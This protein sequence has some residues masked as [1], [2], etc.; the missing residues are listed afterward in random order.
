[1]EQYFEHYAVG[2]AHGS[3]FIRVEEDGSRP[4]LP[5]RFLNL[6]TQVMD[7]HPAP[8]STDWLRARDLPNSNSRRCSPFG[9]ECRAIVLAVRSSPALNNVNNR[10][11][12]ARFKDGRIRWLSRAQIHR[13][14]ST[15]NWRSARDRVRAAP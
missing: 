5:V 11:D 12:V 10:V 14:R 6:F 3:G 8:P 4:P 15:L 1:M 2:Q 9:I 7:L 13:R